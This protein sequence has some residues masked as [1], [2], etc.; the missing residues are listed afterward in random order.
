[1]KLVRLFIILLMIG[2]IVMAVGAVVM[3]FMAIDTDVALKNI[4][5]FHT[6]TIYTNGDTKYTCQMPGCT[7]E[8]TTTVSANCYDE[9]GKAVM[10][11]K[12]RANLTLSNGDFYAD[13]TQSAVYHDDYYTLSPNGSGS[14]RVEKHHDTYE[15]S[16][17]SGSH[18]IKLIRVEGN[19]CDEHVEKT[20]ELYKK[21]VSKAF[22]KGNFVYFW[23]KRFFPWNIPL[24]IILFFL[25]L[26]PLITVES[27]M[28]AD[29]LAREEK[30]KAEAQA[31]ASV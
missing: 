27:I 10:K 6:D 7:K 16:Y 13:D 4:P 18:L 28:N 30:K 12:N 8:A 26:Y 24:M 1:M 17:K 19:Y 9:F 11:C 23:G 15:Y 14:V 25:M 31:E 22:V 5:K 29:I 21:D 20:E 3:R 2:C